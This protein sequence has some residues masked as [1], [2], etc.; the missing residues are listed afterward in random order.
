MGRVKHRDPNN[1]ARLLR[2]KHYEARE[3]L[4]SHMD[5][6]LSLRPQNSLFYS[7][8]F[9]LLFFKIILK[10]WLV[11]SISL[12]SPLNSFVELLINKIIRSMLKSLIRQV[13][14][15]Y[16]VHDVY[17]FDNKRGNCIVSYIISSGSKLFHLIKFN[18]SYCCMQE[19]VELREN[20]QEQKARRRVHRLT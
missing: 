20:S 11:L 2:V 14:V 10:L 16:I 7:S 19:T 12:C 13:R 17:R 4:T 8:S 5:M 18:L 9:L 15:D 3:K 1:T 6:V